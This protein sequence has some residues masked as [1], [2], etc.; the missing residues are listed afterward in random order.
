MRESSAES[1]DRARGLTDEI[2]VGKQVGAPFPDFCTFDSL[3]FCVFESPRRLLEE[4]PGS[5][6]CGTHRKTSQSPAAGHPGTRQR[7][8]GRAWGHFVLRDRCG[9]L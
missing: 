8:R 4:A 9:L 7:P 5:D 3:E 6:P 2:E 1:V